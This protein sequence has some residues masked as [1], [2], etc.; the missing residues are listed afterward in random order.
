MEKDPCP[1]EGSS[2]VAGDNRDRDSDSKLPSEVQSQPG[3]SS[4]PAGLSCDELSEYLLNKGIPE[5]CVAPFRGKWINCI[6][7]K[8]GKCNSFTHIQLLAIYCP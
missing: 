4:S 5:V 2:N 8:I 1:E 6:T 3:P 7:P